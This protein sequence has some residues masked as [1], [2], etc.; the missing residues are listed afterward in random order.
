MRLSS[1]VGERFKEQPSETVLI[2]HSM[3]IRGGYIR[4]VTQGV[5]SLLPPAKRIAHKIENIL[6]EEM[7]RI[8]GQEVMF[9]VTMPRELW[10][11]SGRYLSVGSE[12]LRFKDRNGHE[13]LLGMTH[14]EAAVHMCRNDIKSHT[15]MPFMI[16][17]IQTKFRDEPRSRGGLIRVR[18]FTMK[19]GYSFHVDQDDLQTYYDKCYDAYHRIYKRAGIPQVVS[20]KSDTGM[21]GGSAAHEFMLLCDAGEDT[22]VLCDG[23][24]DGN[25]CGYKA[26]ME[27]AEATLP[28]PPTLE[29]GTGFAAGN[30]L[31]VEEVHT[32]GITTIEDLSSFLG[33]PQER[34]TKAVAYQVDGMDK[35]LIVFLRGDLDVN[36]SKLKIHLKAGIVPAPEELLA[37][38]GTNAGF[39]G[40]IGLDKGKATVLFDVSLKGA[41]GMACGANKNDYHLVGLDI[42]RDFPDVSF[43]D[44]AKVKEGSRCIHCGGEIRI[45]RGIEVG[46]I[47]QLGDKYTKSM[48]MRFTDSNGESKHPIMG[49][50]GIGVGRLMASVLEV[51]HDDN[52]PIWP[53]SIAPWQVH[54]CALRYDDENV[55]TTTEEVYGNLCDVGFETIVDDRNESAGVQFADADL[56]GVPVRVIISPRNLKNGN[57]EV[58]SRDKSLKEAVPVGNLA[59][60]ITRFLDE[61]G[62]FF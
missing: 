7:D 56:L 8:G 43:V 18:E 11:E 62:R 30:P 14:E 47:F 1:L 50:Y 38:A 20:V 46:N 4:Q 49:C 48:N 61:L 26:N 34:L 52:G 15:R 5:Y 44:I 60:T 19:D 22:I 59:E 13:M 36:E 55:K 10:D 12:L 33:L 57:I 3:M 45:S 16:Y 9:P 35:P 29:C 6:R 37:E 51:C 27:V 28:V 40:P 58:V 25:G 17:Q 21:M 54:I 41:I 53:V 42:S 24:G 31:S 39:M 23:D 2:S 32:P